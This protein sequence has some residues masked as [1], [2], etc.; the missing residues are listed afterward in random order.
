MK[1]LEIFNEK[2][3]NF[4]DL[5]SS[6]QIDFF[7][8][9]LLIERKYDG[10]V[11]KDITECFDL[12]HLPPYSNINSYLNEI[13]TLISTPAGNIPKDAKAKSRRL[14]KKW[15]WLLSIVL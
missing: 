7:A 6:S 2:V 12:L 9:F 15:N 13:F 14:P 1:E 11:T 3:E 8:Y 10:I 4:E 5:P